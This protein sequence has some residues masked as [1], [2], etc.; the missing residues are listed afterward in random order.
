[1]LSTKVSPAARAATDRVIREASEAAQRAKLDPH[2][3]KKGVSVKKAE[4]A[5][6]PPH[7][8]GKV[9]HVVATDPRAKPGEK[10]QRIVFSESEVDVVTAR[11][12]LA[13]GIEP[14]P[15]KR[16]PATMEVYARP[17]YKQIPGWAIGV[18]V[19]LVALVIAVPMLFKS[20]PSKMF[21]V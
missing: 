10:L 9:A 7:A 13:G 19:A 14:P 11:P 8:S 4:P 15:P 16:M 20:T 12:P 21:E 3:N 6:T 5:P 17:W 2:P 1:M 18:V